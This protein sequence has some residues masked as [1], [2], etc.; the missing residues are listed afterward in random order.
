MV[1]RL[2][3][4]GTRITHERVSSPRT[5]LVTGATGFVGSALVDALA[6]RGDR[7]VVVSRHPE[8]AKQTLPSASAFV[9]AIDARA[10]AGV[11]AIVNL[12][13]EP[14]AGRWTAAK[15][16][17]IETS[18][19]S[20]T[21][22]IATAIAERPSGERPRVL[23]SASA[24]GYY[25]DRGETVLEESSSAGG[26][27]LS[28]VCVKW[29]EAANEAKALGVR[30]ATTR[31][32]LVMGDGGAL[33]AMRPLFAMG[34][35]GPL[36]DGRQFWAWIHLADVIGLLLFALDRDEVD[37]PMNVTAPTPVRQAE[38]A[39]ALGKAMHRPAF[40]PAPAFAIRAATGDFAVELLASRRVVPTRALALGYAFRYPE[41]EPAL[42]AIFEK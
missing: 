30:V 7:I 25:G 16:A 1:A 38:H 23:V 15:K 17:A 22:A 14:V 35:G 40:V 18:R 24:I 33:A 32:G 19:V 27:F 3:H 11:D 41:L 31:L 10:L 26:D 28:S 12:A 5:I 37:G 21:S 42:R 6:A 8:K 29:E 2:T 39:R 4:E 34:F 20:V 13:G 9:R 36:G